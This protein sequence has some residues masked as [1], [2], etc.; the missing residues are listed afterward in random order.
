MFEIKGKY[1][2]AKMYT[3]DYDEGVVSQVY[4]I[5]NCPAFAGQKVVCMPDVHLGSA[6]PCGL[7]ATIGDWVNPN[8]VGV[9]IGCSVSMIVLDKKIPEEKFADFE[10]KVKIAVPF[11]MET[12]DKTV[13]DCKDFYKFLT[14][15][16]N[17]YRQMWPEMLND[18]PSVVTEKWVSEQLMRLHM[19][20]GVF[21]KQIRTCGSGNH[22]I[23]YD[24]NFNETNTGDCIPAAVTFHFGSRNFGVKVCKFWVDRANNPI[25]KARLKE[26]TTEFKAEY[27]KTHSN[28]HEFKAALDSRIEEEKSK[29]INGYLTG[30]N[31]RGYLQDMCFCQLYATYNH[32]AAHDAVTEI[33]RKYNIKVVRE[34]TSVHN[35]IDLEDHCLRKS[36]I[37]AYAGEEIIVPFNMRDGVAVCEGLSN[38]EWL[39]SCAHGAGRKMSRSAAKQRIS[40]DEFK[41]TMKDVYST[42][43]GLETLDE[44]PQA[45]K[46][47]SEIKDLIQETCVIKQMLIP[48]INIKG[49]EIEKPWLKNK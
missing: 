8:H 43:V 41:E 14:R 27:K 7:V 44:A 4:D 18:L 10:H 23:E 22:F 49:A 37:R 25:S 48:R 6:G 1:T 46:D 19:D 13:I 38:S 28:M 12:H 29:H 17:R 3:N 32:M 24:E 21:Y 11:G 26:I 47:T 36:S 45:Y 5:V 33:L 35:F 2:S 42:S 40:L 15:G 31:M 34:I 30:D 9:D 16:F 20:E 39:N